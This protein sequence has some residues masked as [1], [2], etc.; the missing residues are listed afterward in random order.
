MPLDGLDNVKKMI[1]KNKREANE[2]VKGV[3]LAGLG[4]I[5]EAT[6]ADKGVHRNSWLLTVGFTSSFIS[7][8]ADGTGS[9]SFRSLE[10]MPEW[11][12]NKKI[13]FT[14]SAPAITTLEYGGFPNPVKKGSY[15]KK[16]NSYEILSINGFSTQAPNGWVR[17]SLI[18]M[19]NKIRSL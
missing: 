14:N 6:P 18:A 16:S 3:Y 4:N 10:Q 19:Q 9:A 5:I 1:A 12:L 13:Y 8:N 11:I 17:S 2:K 7:R 15:I